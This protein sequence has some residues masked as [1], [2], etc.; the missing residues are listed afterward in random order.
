M[1]TG[2]GETDPKLAKF[3]LGHDRKDV[4]AGVETDSRPCAGHPDAR[5]PLVGSGLDE[6]QRQCPRRR[7]PGRIY[8][9]YALYLVKYIQAMEKEGVA[10][11]AI[12]IQNEPLN[13]K[14]TP[15]MQWQINQQMVFLRDHLYPAF[16]KAGLKTKV[17]CSTITSTGPTIPSPC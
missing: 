10:I 16:T 5:V 11:D 1:T 17:I 9:V 14:N 7:P 3:D 13:S 4:L 2:G 15:S 6:N 12:T 8:P